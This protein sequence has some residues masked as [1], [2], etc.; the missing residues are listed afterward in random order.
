MISGALRL[1][2]KRKYYA[3]VWMFQNFLFY[4]FNSKIK[5]KKFKE[6][7]YNEKELKTTRQIAEMIK[8]LLQ[9]VTWQTQK[10]KDQL[11]KSVSIWHPKLN[12]L[13]SI[14]KKQFP[15]NLQRSQA[16]KYFQTKTYWHLTRKQI[17]FQLP[18]QNNVA[19][20]QLFFQGTTLQKMQ[21]L[22]PST[23]PPPPPSPPSQKRK[24]L[25]MAG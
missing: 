5:C 7:G 22:L 14:F 23:H 3:F 17:A 21:T 9:T 13:L 25:A 10:N 15:S 19:T 18:S 20:Q 16:F 1:T 6:Y 11:T 12:A 8:K 4:L 24:I 2:V